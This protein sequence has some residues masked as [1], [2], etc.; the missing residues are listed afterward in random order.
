MTEMPDPTPPDSR[1]EYTITVDN[2]TA[3]SAADGTYHVTATSPVEAVITA[4]FS[5]RPEM[6]YTVSWTDPEVDT[7]TT[8]ETVTDEDSTA[9]H[10]IQIT[11]EDIRTYVRN[12]L[13][14]TD[15]DPANYMFLLFPVAE[16]DDYVSLEVADAVAQRYNDA[17]VDSDSQRTPY[18]IP[19]TGAQ[20][21]TLRELA[22]ALFELHWDVTQRYRGTVRVTI[23]V[24]VPVT[25]TPVDVCEPDSGLL[26]LITKTDA[27]K[28]PRY[29][30]GLVDNLDSVT[31][32]EPYETVVNGGQCMS[33]VV[34]LVVDTHA[35]TALQDPSVVTAF[36]QIVRDE[37]EGYSDPHDGH[38]VDVLNVDVLEYAPVEIDDADDQTDISQAH[39]SL[40]QRVITSIKTVRERLLTGQ[41]APES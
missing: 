33:A 24:H 36:D 34:T 22:D 1:T 30:L 3:D 13:A 7:T 28:R 10:A 21:Q 37:F 5:H 9:S 35:S 26:R 23:E 15:T 8:A 29:T 32:G 19:E 12:Q 39:P 38:M 25:E 18:T 40:R 41:T 2:T 11:D 4:P 17:W 6:T 16:R 14:E 31:I 20:Y 27:G